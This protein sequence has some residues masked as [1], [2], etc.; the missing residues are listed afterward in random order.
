[1]NNHGDIVGR[2]SVRGP[3]GIDWNRG[4]LNV[5]DGTGGRVM[6]NLQEFFEDEG[7][8]PEFDYDNPVGNSYVS[9]AQ[10]INDSGQILGRIWTPGVGGT[11]FRYSPATLNE[12]GDPV[13]AQLDDLGDYFFS[14]LN[15]NGDAVGDESQSADL[16]VWTEAGG[17]VNLGTP[18]DGEGTWV[19][20]MNDAG[21]IVV[22]NSPFYRAWRHTPGVGFENLGTLNGGKRSF[23]YSINASGQVTGSSIASRGTRAFRYSNNTGM[24]DLGNLGG[25]AYG[26]S[27]NNHGDVV[28]ISETD[29]GEQHLFLYT[30]ELGIVDLESWTIDLPDDY[31]GG[32]IPFY[33]DD[34][35]CNDSLTVCGT[36]TGG[37]SYK[38]AYV[39]TVFS[40]P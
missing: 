26:C 5:S 36:A 23:G 12:F 2:S 7:L 21:Q 22:S 38:E 6:I 11:A 35:I 18:P 13:P 19:S 16:F 9:D 29:G 40:A 17:L 8:L 33:A 32:L 14:D 39:I 28:G 34:I 1:M 24:E 27:I 30:N 15:N 20:D 10:D 25:S 3:N 4:F 37:P 31:A